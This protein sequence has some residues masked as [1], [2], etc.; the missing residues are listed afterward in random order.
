MVMKPGSSDE[1]VCWPFGL[2]QRREGAKAPLFIHIGTRVGIQW[3]VVLLGV[4]GTS[5]AQP[6]PPATQPVVITVTASVAAFFSADLYSKDSGYV[7]EVNADIG[8]HVKKGDVLATIDD[9]EL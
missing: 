5:F 7:A 8:D 9:P 6:A 1:T 3:M 2:T 4:V